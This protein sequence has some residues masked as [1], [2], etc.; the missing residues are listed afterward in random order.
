M[1]M[2]VFS[3]L[4]CTSLVPVSA[5]PRGKWEPGVWY[6]LDFGG[7]GH[8]RGQGSLSLYP[9]R[10]GP[11]REEGPREGGVGKEGTVT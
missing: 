9:G 10:A 4:P 8:K 5:V 7:P 11:G 2:A 1:C 6:G 3:G